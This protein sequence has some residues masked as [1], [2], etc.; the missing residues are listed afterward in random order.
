MVTCK[1]IG[2]LGN[3]M[4]QIAA[5]YAH[6]L[7]VGAKFY[8]PEKSE[9]PR[10]WPTYFSNLPKIP[11]GTAPRSV[12][13]EPAHSYNPIPN[14]LTSVRLEGYFQSELYF[15]KYRQQIIDLFGLPWS[16]KKGWV[17]IHVR[18]QDYLQFQKAFPPVSI[19][20]IQNAI[21]SFSSIGDYDFMFFSDDIN[22]CKKNFTGSNIYF[23]KG[24]QPLKELSEMSCCEHNIIA[25]STFSWWA[26]WLNQNPDKIAIAPQVWFGPENAHLETKDIV[27][28]NWVRL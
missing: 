15:S 26:A 1:L 11:R 23:S 7:S 19:E 14:D 10:I 5:A 20:Y 3:Q 4:F 27:P 24:G 17:S 6:S 8:C 12:Y 2:R 18:R 16:L 28:K 21:A 25:N 13:K 9:S 22:W